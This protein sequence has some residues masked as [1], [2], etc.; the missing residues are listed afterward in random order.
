MFHIVGCSEEGIRL[1]SAGNPI[2]L[3]FADEQKHAAAALLMMN[4]PL[5]CRR[6]RGRRALTL[7]VEQLAVDGIIIIHRRG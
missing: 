2:R 3:E 5:P 7:P 4:I 1:C 6:I